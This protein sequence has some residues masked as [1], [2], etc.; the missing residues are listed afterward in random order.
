MQH[1]FIINKEPLHLF[2]FC[3]VIFIN[4][5]T[6]LWPLVIK[7]ELKEFFGIAGTVVATQR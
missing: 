5:F 6:L 3:L 7:D 2:F 4:H 1:Q